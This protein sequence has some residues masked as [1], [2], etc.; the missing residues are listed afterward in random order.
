MCNVIAGSGHQGTNR[1]TTPVAHQDNPFAFLQQAQPSGI[2]TDHFAA[3]RTDVRVVGVG[4]CDKHFG[5][6]HHQQADR[7]RL[8]PPAPEPP[9]AHDRLAKM[10]FTTCWGSL[11]LVTGLPMTK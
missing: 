3:L 11:A 4:M 6:P 1:R 2:D 7:P 8:A 9:D 10:S 5:G